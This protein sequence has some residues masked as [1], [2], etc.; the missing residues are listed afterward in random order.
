MEDKTCT[1]ESK[2]LLP[3]NSWHHVTCVKTK[4]SLAIII[5]AA[6]DSVTKADALFNVTFEGTENGKIWFIIFQDL[7]ALEL[8]SKSLVS[9]DTLVTL[10]LYQGTTTYFLF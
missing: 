6:E 9:V 8:C 1:V 4:N 5:D 7:F 2:K 10:A 3:Q